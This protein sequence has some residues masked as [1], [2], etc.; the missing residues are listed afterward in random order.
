MACAHATIRN[1]SPGGVCPICSR[2]DA[3]I[4]TSAR[5]VRPLDGWSNAL[6]GI[7]QVLQDKRLSTQ[8]R[9]EVVSS[10]YA[11]ALYRGDDLAAR[12]V[13]T[14]P[15]EMLRE[16]YEISVSDELK[17][18]A[19]AND[20]YEDA[21]ERGDDLE[22][23]ARRRAR[24]DAAIKGKGLAE[25][26]KTALECLEADE[27]FRT[28]LCYRRAY[29]GGAIFVGANDGQSYLTKPLNEDAVSSV[30]FLTVI[31]P[32]EMV[33]LYYY[34][35]PRAPK[36]GRPAVWQIQTVSPGVPIPDQGMGT[37]GVSHLMVHESR[38]IIF[39]GPRA[40]RRVNSEVHAGFG[41]SV[42]TRVNRVLS[43]FNVS[44]A[45]A[46]ILVHDFAQAVFKIKGL[47]EA[48][49]MDQDELLKLRMRAV[50][51]S[52]STARAILIDSEEEFKR[53]Q[54][55]VSGLPE[56]LDRFCARLAA[57]ADMPL[58]LLMGQSPGGLNATG[59]SDIR[60]FYDRVKS[61]QQRDLRPQLERL[62][63][64]VFKSL[65]GV[66]DQW[67]LTFRP[68]WQPSE[69][70]QA[71]ARL[72]QATI[73]EKYVALDVLSASEVTRSRFGGDCYSFETRVDFDARL[74]L[75]VAA[76]PPVKVAG[77]DPDDEPELPPAGF[78]GPPGE[79]GANPFAPGAP[80]PELE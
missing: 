61:A 66:P 54:T 59:E 20:T 53:E 19:D 43:D 26:V 36:F 4:A 22:W 29:G 30:D 27:A 51:L 62:I 17:A 23:R 78:G 13:E 3:E 68:L 73:D 25:R 35:D 45:S 64:L 11:E 34:A 72:V 75:E 5:P 2:A 52:R 48:M 6:T 39:Q 42:F 74:A 41:D 28:A 46:G 80:D 1:L 79:P 65:G 15:N 12:I 8:F 63:K 10:E 57:A 18:E 71:D 56:L 49:A 14:W 44:W 47:A 38:L 50:E 16:G 24:R 77:E 21:V 32:R 7:G 60:F 33:P 76:P 69:K 37:Y 67:N 58:T 40:T 31:E 9:L 55:P 70:E